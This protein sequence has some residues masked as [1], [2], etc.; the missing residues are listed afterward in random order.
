[1]PNNPG[2]IDG[3]YSIGEIEEVK[4]VDPGKFGEVRTGKT[5]NMLKFG[6]PVAVIVVIALLVLAAF[7]LHLL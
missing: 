6:L 3:D 1:M 4:Y 7:G 2:R 5:Q